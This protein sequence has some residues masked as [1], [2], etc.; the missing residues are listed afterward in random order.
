MPTTSAPTTHRW[1]RQEYH[2]LADAGFLGEDDPVELIEGEIVQMSPQNTPHAVAVR[3]AR[4]VLQR[5]FP[6]DEYLVDEQLPLALGP[7]S[8][9]EPDVSVV[10]GN[11]RDFLEEH[12]A[13][14][15][16]VVEVADASLQF[17]RTRKRELYARYGLPEY[18]IVNLV[19]R[20]L[21]VHRA[22][23][24]DAYAETT[25]HSADDAAS[26]RNHSVAVSDLLP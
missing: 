26:L 1:T 7:D 2:A 23:T 14:A 24:D 8:E 16:L 11:P 19:D 3:L 20:H 4:R 10:E 9:P 13:S 15:V 21:E 18:W 17:D 12:P 6:G 22:P 5:I 25:V